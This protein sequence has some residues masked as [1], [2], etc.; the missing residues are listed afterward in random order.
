MMRTELF[1]AAGAGACVG[2]TAAYLYL[3]KTDPPVSPP[4]P[5][6]PAPASASGARVVPIAEA[7]PMATASIVETSQTILALLKRFNPTVVEGMDPEVRLA[8]RTFYST[9]GTG[10]IPEMMS[11][12]RKAVMRAAR[13][14]STRRAGGRVLPRVSPSSPP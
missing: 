12:W 7:P 5:P 6:P 3:R 8:K 2:V 9:R 10:S 4:A 1:A 13:T 14:A 11:V